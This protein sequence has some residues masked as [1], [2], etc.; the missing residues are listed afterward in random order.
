MKI[1]DSQGKLFSK[2]NIVDLAIVIA[3]IV[4]ALSAFMKF[5]KSEKTMSSDKVL[6]YTME[7][8][9]IRKPTIDA[10][11]K[12]SEIKDDETGKILGEIIDVEVSKAVDNVELADGTYKKVQ[13]QGKFDLLLTVRVKGTETEDNFYTMDGQK[14]I[15]G[16]EFD[17][18]NDE[19]ICTGTVRSVHIAEEP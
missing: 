18:N 3:V 15:V 5:D 11:N 7:V 4:L 12:N 19:V 17:I 9:K 1:I 13:L 6:E 8:T 16:Y 10:L 14:L 2:I